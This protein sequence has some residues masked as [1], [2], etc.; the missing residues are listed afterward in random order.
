M[1]LYAEGLAQQTHLY[2]INNHMENMES[3]FS[4]GL[5]VTGILVTLVVCLRCSDEGAAGEMFLEDG[6]ASP[7]ARRRAAAAGGVLISSWS[8][9]R[10]SCHNTLRS[11]YT[12]A[13]LLAESTDT[14][15]G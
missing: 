12:A 3:V 5:C 8:A 11:H 2:F 10:S 4:F 13:F 14:S 6:E 7:G 9:V 15:A 1:K